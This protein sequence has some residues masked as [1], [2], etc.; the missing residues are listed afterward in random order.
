MSA[1]ETARYLRRQCAATE[2][3]VTNGAH[4][5]RNGHALI[6]GRITNDVLSAA[7]KVHSR[8]GPGLLER[9]YKACM[10]YKL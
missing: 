4:R 8:L 9:P 10:R 6:H 2:D 5:R 1:S 7:Y 3:T